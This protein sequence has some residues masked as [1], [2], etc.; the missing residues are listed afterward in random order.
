MQRCTDSSLREPAFRTAAGFD[1]V[2]PWIP[3]HRG[4]GARSWIDPQTLH[5]FVA[6]IETGTIGAAAER[7]HMVASAVSKRLSDL[8]DSLKT[9]LLKRSNRSIEPTAA[10]TE[11]L[12]LARSVLNDLDNIH[13]R[14]K[15][16]AL[17]ARGLVRVFAN[18]STITEFMPGNLR[19]FMARFP[20]VQVQLQEKI[21]S[22][23]QQGIASNAADVGLYAHGHSHVEDLISLPYRRD[24]LVVVVPL[25]HPLAVCRQVGI[26]ETLACDYVGLHT[27]SYINEQLL[28]AAQEAGLSFSVPHTGHQLRCAQCHGRG[29]NGRRADAEVDRGAVRPPREAAGAD[30][31]RV[32]GQ[33]RAAHLRSL[34]GEPARRGTAVRR[35]LAVGGPVM[36]VALHRS[37]CRGIEMRDGGVVKQ[38]FTG[39]RGVSIIRLGS[40]RVVDGHP[41]RG[42][43][44]VGSTSRIEVFMARSLSDAQAQRN[45]PVSTR[46]QESTN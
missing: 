28:K 24:E 26:A 21:S 23:V 36:N 46:A 20:Q 44:G 3:G 15:D 8:E 17:G 25:D 12:G 30:A 18:I 14:L 10:G 7:E 37:T 27:C 11:L 13:G 5:L 9:S 6:V 4:A 43:H 16:H 31:D 42:R 32:L 2:P 38:R 19:S 41:K 39:C 22:A 33:P 35:A 40:G 29:G 34:A 45:D 1:E